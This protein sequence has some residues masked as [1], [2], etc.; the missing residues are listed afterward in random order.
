MKRIKVLSAENNRMGRSEFRRELGLQNG[1]EMDASV[2]Y[3]YRLRV[4]LDGC[5]RSHAQSRWFGFA[6]RRII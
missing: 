1:L 4:S 2:Q 3:L 6:C 5:F